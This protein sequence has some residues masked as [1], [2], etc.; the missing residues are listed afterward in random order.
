[1]SAR[2]KAQ[3]AFPE[4]LQLMSA[5]CDAPA[6][7]P[8][9]FRAKDVLVCFSCG[10]SCEERCYMSRQTKQQQA[11]YEYLLVRCSHPRHTNPPPISLVSKDASASIT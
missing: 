9:W 6:D 2:S 3:T 11:M 10:Y 1:M 5:Q 7:M 8:D 4:F